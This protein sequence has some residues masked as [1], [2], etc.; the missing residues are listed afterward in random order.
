MEEI[1]SWRR[2][3]II[4]KKRTY[5]PKKG[6]IDVGFRP[7]TGRRFIAAIWERKRNYAAFVDKQVKLFQCIP[8]E[9]IA[10]IKFS[11]RCGFRE[12]NMGITETKKS[13]DRNL[14]REALQEGEKK[15]RILL[16][17]IKDG[18]TIHDRFKIIDANQGYAAMFGCKP[19]EIICL[20]P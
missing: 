16:D 8:I 12:E 13:I 3:K 1:R 4:L 18:V 5:N 11:R 10:L 14:A 19:D 6:I 7:Y 17:T 20:P 15:F 9:I 2:R